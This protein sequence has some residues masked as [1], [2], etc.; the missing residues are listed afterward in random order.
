MYKSMLYI[1]RNIKRFKAQVLFFGPTLVCVR[2]HK[3]TPEFGD[4]LQRLIVLSI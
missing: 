1:L 4:F 2:V 3:T